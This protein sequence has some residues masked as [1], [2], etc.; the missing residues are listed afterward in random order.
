MKRIAAYLFVGFGLTNC[1]ESVP[2]PTP[3]LVG[4]W[5][6]LTVH[7]VFRDRIIELPGNDEWVKNEPDSVLLE[8]TANGSVNLVHNG[9]AK[10]TET[11]YTYQGG[12]MRWSGKPGENWVVISRTHGKSP[13]LETAAL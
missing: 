12:R 2:N 13:S 1:A 5:E 11:T 8:F 6:Q 9:V 7:K 4:K 10:P 3:S